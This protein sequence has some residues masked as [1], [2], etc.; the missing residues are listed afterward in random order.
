M[1]N[2]K[3]KLLFGMVAFVALLIV[4]VFVYNHFVDSEGSSENLVSIGEEDN[5]IVA[6]DFVM[7]NEQNEEVQLSGFF[8]KPIVLN[9]WATWCPSCVAE[10]PYFEKLYQEMGDEVHFI[11]VN[12]LDGQRETRA[13]VDDYMI[14]NDYHFPV[15]FDITGEGAANYGVRS[16]PFSIFIDANGY[17]VGAAQGTLDEAGLRQGIRMAQ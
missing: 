17:V 9:F 8:G 4:A 16:I 12:L 6:T 10:S 5:P 13:R 14:N 7:T 2:K 11:K 15:Y 1:E 3:T